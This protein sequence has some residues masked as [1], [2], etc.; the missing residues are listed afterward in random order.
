MC[1]ILFLLSL[2]IIDCYETSLSNSSTL[3]RKPGTASLRVSVDC[4]SKGD[5][6]N[7]HVFGVFT[8]PDEVIK[9][10]ELLKEARFRLIETAVIA[11][12]RFFVKADTI[13]KLK[14]ITN[15]EKHVERALD[16]GIEPMVWFINPDKPFKNL[17]SFS[18]Y[19]KNVLRYLTKGEHGGHYYNIRLL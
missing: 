13:K 18:L 2:L 1:I 8:N 7:N 3:P 6:I 15:T 14:F 9:S 10:Y 19:T 4:T 5:R 17:N 16:L 12:E 11:D